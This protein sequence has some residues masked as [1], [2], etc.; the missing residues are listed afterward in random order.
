[1]R[2]GRVASLRAWLLVAA[3]L[4][5][6]AGGQSNDH[7]PEGPE[8]HGGHEGGHLPGPF[9]EHGHEEGG[10]EGFHRPAAECTMQ[11]TKDAVDASS[12]YVTCAGLEY[13][14]FMSLVH[15][16][17]EIL[18]QAAA[19]FKG[20]VEEIKPDIAPGENPEKTEEE[21]KEM[22]EQLDKAFDACVEDAEKADDTG[23][24]EATT[25]FLQ[26]LLGPDSKICTC[27]PAFVDKMPECESWARFHHFGLRLEELCNHASGAI[28]FPGPVEVLTPV[29]EVQTE[30]ELPQ[31]E[32][33]EIKAVE[34][35]TEKASATAAVEPQLPNTWGPCPPGHEVHPEDPKDCQPVGASEEYGGPDGRGPPSGGGGG[36]IFGLGMSVIGI[37]AV[38]GAI[39]FGGVWA[40]TK[41]SSST[42]QP[43]V[44]YMATGLEDDNLGTELGPFGREYA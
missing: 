12:S 41:F 37:L 32:D 11:Q 43:G 10:P 21:V 33:I 8:G 40:W 34:P 16:D 38:G 3:A 7:K 18:G 25:D 28:M 42:R 44:R 27:F 26:K 15:A 36:G 2:A 1:M 19:C 24:T 9:G 17:M 29:E 31:G 13:A 39:G 20:K 6:V 5:A 14:D 35:E 23:A 30:T 22:N 4:A